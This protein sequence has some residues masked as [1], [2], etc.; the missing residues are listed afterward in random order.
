MVFGGG[1]MS[2]ELESKTPQELRE[3]LEKLQ[4][5]KQIKKLKKE[6]EQ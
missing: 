5:I 6:L 3:I 1:Y 4:L 2:E